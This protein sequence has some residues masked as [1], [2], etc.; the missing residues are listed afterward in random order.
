MS[1]EAGDRQVQ[2]DQ[3]QSGTVISFEIPKMSLLHSL[4]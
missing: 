3:E 2:Y 1:T 4:L